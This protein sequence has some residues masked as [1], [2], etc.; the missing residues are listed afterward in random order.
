MYKVSHIKLSSDI[1]NK[2]AYNHRSRHVE[3]YR[4]TDTHTHKQ[5]EPRHCYCLWGGHECYCIFTV[6]DSPAPDPTRHS[7]SHS[8]GRK[9]PAHEETKRTQQSTA[10]QRT[11]LHLYSNRSRDIP[12]DRTAQCR[13]SSTP[14]NRHRHPLNPYSVQYTIHIQPIVCQLLAYILP[15]PT[16]PCPTPYSYL[17]V[18][19]RSTPEAV[20]GDLIVVIKGGK[21]LADVTQHHLIRVIDLCVCVC[22]WRRERERARETETERDRDR[23]KDRERERDISQKCDCE[24]HTSRCWAQ[25]THQ[26][27]KQTYWLINNVIPSVSAYPY[28]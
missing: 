20:A 21:R 28:I 14:P 27:Y 7:P 13:A 5:T 12:Q 9:T 25:H 23:E 17:W 11:E 6:S 24:E 22:V 2:L 4:N 3:T 8:G 1:Q 10:E 26:A 15:Y 16:L 18:P 19:W